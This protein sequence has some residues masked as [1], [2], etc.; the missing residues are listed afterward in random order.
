MVSISPTSKFKAV[1][2]NFSP[3]PVDPEYLITAF[4]GRQAYSSFNIPITV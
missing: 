2:I 1:C 4:L 3:Y